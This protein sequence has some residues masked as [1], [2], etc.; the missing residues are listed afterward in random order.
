KR[1]LFHQLLHHFELVGA[2]GAAEAAQPQAGRGVL[3]IALDEADAAVTEPDDV[4]GQLLGGAGVVDAHRRRAVGL[5]VRG[6][7]HVGHAG[8][9]EHPQH[10][11]IVG[12]RRGQEHAVEPQLRH[13]RAGALGH[14][15]RCI[16]ELLHQQVIA[17]AAAAVEDADLDAVGVVAAGVAEQVTDQ[18]RA[19][20]GQAARR[21]VRLVAERRGGARH[22]LAHLVADIGFLVHHPRHGLHRDPGQLGDIHHGR[23]A[24][25]Q[26][27]LWSGRGGA[28]AHSCSGRVGLAQRRW[29]PAY[30][31]AANAGQFDQKA[32]GRM[33]HREDGLRTERQGRDGL[34]AGAAFGFAVGDFGLNLYWQGL[35]LFLVYF[36][37]DVLGLPASWA[38]LA[39]LA[40]SV[41]DG[42]SD[43]L[44]GLAAD[45]TRTRWGRYR[46]YLLLGSLPL[47]LAFV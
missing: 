14:V 29:L 17:G 8:L 7:A 25:R 34:A 15:R 11:G 47:A 28:L 46:P 6:D 20:A 9:L 37:T 26:A 24:R 12:D 30:D 5:G 38:G 22:P 39:Y 4:L 27:G 19:L 10:L 45:R 36:H 31:S 2:H 18:E 32:D 40:A 1:A 13:Q 33:R 35:G 43:P 21:E 42:L 23:L 3:G 41:W 16:V 44:L